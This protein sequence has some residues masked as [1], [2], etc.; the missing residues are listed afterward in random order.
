VL[1]FLACDGV[2]EK[3]LEALVNGGLIEGVLEALVNDL[4]GRVLEALVDGLSEGV[5]AA[6]VGGRIDGVLEGCTDDLL[7][8]TGRHLVRI[9]G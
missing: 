6:L 7:V 5:L 9:Q 1:G 2:V 3:G 8:D 4:D